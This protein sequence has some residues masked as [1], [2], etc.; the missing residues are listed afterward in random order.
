MHSLSDRQLFT[1]LTV[2]IVALFGSSIAFGWTGPPASPPGANVPAPINVGSVAQVKNGS[3]G[4]N[5]LAVFGNSLLAGSGGSVVYL[6]FKNTAGESGYGIRDNNGTMEYKN[7]GGAWTPFSA[8]GSSSSSSSSSSGSTL[9]TIPG[10]YTF[11][12][13]NYTSTLTVELWGGGG[14]GTGYH[15]AGGAGTASTFGSSLSAG[16]GGA[17]RGGFQPAGGGAGGIASGGTTNQNGSAGSTSGIGGNSPSG[18]NGG[19]TSMAPGGVP[20]GGGAA[21]MCTECSSGGGGAGAHVIRTY[22]VGQ[23]TPGSTVT[24]VVGSGGVGGTTAYYTGEPLGGA[25]ARGQVNLTWQ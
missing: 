3:I 8:G 15:Y 5:A 24:L 16:G 17:G 1:L 22:S 20:G 18:G 13:P 25:G 14:G 21:A 11:T 9:Y 7:A 10:T 6:N 23:L 4:M 19:T 2:S 12:V